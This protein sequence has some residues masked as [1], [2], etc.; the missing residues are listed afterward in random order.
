M[1]ALVEVLCKFGDIV[2]VTEG[3]FVFV[4]PGCEIRVCLAQY[5]LFYNQGK[6]IYIPRSVQSCLGYVN[7]VEKNSHIKR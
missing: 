7:I 2:V 5:M 6:L 4:I 3:T 1:H